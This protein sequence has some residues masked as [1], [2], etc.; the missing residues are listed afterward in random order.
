MSLDLQGNV[1][2]LR[3]HSGKLLKTIK[4][5]DHTDNRHHELI[6]S[7][8]L[9]PAWGLTQGDVK[10]PLGWIAFFDILITGLKQCIS[11]SAGRV[12]IP[13]AILPG[14]IYR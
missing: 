11:D 6:K 9:Q 14:G 1:I 12:R 10:S 13:N 7:L 8:G 5:V 3:P 2:P 4:M